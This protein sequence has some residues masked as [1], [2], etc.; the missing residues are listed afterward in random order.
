MTRRPGVRACERCGGRLAGAAGGARAGASAGGRARRGC[1]H[2]GG[3]GGGGGGGGGGQPPW[4]PTC[5]PASCMRARPCAQLCAS[6]VAVARLGA[7]R[8]CS[9]AAARR[10]VRFVL[11]PPS[12]T[13]LGRRAWLLRRQGLCFTTS[14][15]CATINRQAR[16]WGGGFTRARTRR[17]MP[18]ADGACWRAGAGA[19]HVL[20]RGAQRLGDPPQRR[21]CWA[22]HAVPAAVREGQL[23]P[24][25]RPG[26]LRC[27][28]RPWLL[29]RWQQR[30]ALA[31][32]SARCSA[33]HSS[34][35]TGE[36]R[37]CSELIM[38]VEA[39]PAA[40]ACWRTGPTGA[41]AAGDGPPGRGRRS[42]R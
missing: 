7:A 5:S 12:R 40:R 29:Q 13:A 17:G 10:G 22:L 4:R 2:G 37:Y 3:H 31:V 6:L 26:A 15:C 35:S 8:L 20:R 19:L 18:V 36:L 25:L 16:V 9:R 30:V 32:P 39:V 24:R 42:G 21:L 23:L 14:Q 1:G 27:C 38:L 33:C 11:R 34:A 41:A 28:P